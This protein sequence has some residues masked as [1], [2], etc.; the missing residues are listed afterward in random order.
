M[1]NFALV[2]LGLDMQF[3]NIKRGKNKIVLSLYL[4]LVN[5]PF[6]SCTSLEHQVH[7][8]L[9][10]LAV[11]SD[12]TKGNAY[13]PSAGTRNLRRAPLLDK[14]QSTVDVATHHQEGDVAHRANCKHTAA[15][16]GRPVQYAKAFADPLQCADQVTPA[17]CAVQAS[18][19]APSRI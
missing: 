4:P 15:S 7:S 11:R 1:F 18:S 2:V 12:P 19:R 10:C 17:A 3:V 16:P 14:L 9:L 13:N 5:R 8:K 6:L